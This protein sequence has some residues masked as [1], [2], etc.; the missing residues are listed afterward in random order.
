MENWTADEASEHLLDYQKARWPQG[1]PVEFQSIF[2]AAQLYWAFRWLGDE[3]NGAR[4]RIWK[5]YPRLLRS[6]AERLAL[7]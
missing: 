1:A 2:A 4:K 5:R 7:I 3:S 6:A